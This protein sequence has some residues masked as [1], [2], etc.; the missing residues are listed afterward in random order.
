[1]GNNY[2]LIEGYA[3]TICKN[4]L[5]NVS[6]VL[7]TPDEKTVIY[8]HNSSENI[9]L[10]NEEPLFEIL[11]VLIGKDDN[12][13][14]AFKFEKTESQESKLESIPRNGSL[15]N[16]KYQLGQIIRFENNPYRYGVI[17]EVTDTNIKLETCHPFRRQHLLLKVNSKKV[18]N[19]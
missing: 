11:K 15:K 1:M 2:I 18:I 8:R 16:I 14:G 3:M 6:F 19:N 13:Q 9:N 12:F 7:T 4:D 17:L 10:N 5:V